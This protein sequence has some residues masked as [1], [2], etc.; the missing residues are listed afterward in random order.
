[1]EFAE[2]VKTRRSV[3]SY[4]DEPVSEDDLMQICEAGR[5]APSAL[6]MQPWEFI[7]M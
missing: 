3:R 4:T 6:N 5:W 1:M 7:L 2:L